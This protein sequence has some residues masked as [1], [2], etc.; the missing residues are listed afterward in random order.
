MDVRGKYLHE[1]STASDH[2]ILHIWQW[3]VLGAANKNWRL[4]PDPKVLEELVRLRVR[5]RWR[6]QGVSIMFTFPLRLDC[7]TV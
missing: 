2:N 6:F 7:A 1:A 5:L 3:L 4:L